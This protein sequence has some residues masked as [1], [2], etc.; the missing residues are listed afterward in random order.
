MPKASKHK[1]YTLPSNFNEMNKFIEVNKIQL[2]EHIVASIEYAIDKKLSFVEIF[3][4][5]NSDFVVTL[6][7]NQFKENLD[8]VYSY[9]IEKDASQ[10]I[11][12]YFAYLLVHSFSYSQVFTLGICKL[13]KTIRKLKEQTTKTIF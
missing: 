5:K 12:Y 8:N 3:S 7:T 1:L 4:F 9:Y 11:V 13:T 10:D 6:P 2:M